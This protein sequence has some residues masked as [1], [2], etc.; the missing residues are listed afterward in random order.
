MN[1]SFFSHPT[2]RE[3][4]CSPLVSL[5][6]SPQGEAENQ[7]FSSVFLFLN[8]RR[9]RGSGDRP[10]SL[11]AC[12]PDRSVRSTFSNSNGRSQRFLLLL[13]VSHAFE[14]CKR[15]SLS[16]PHKNSVRSQKLSLWI[17][18]TTTSTLQRNHRR[19]NQSLFGNCTSLSSLW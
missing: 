15:L 16:S 7:P 9:K 4:V 5:L 13:L 2:T 8:S 3:G 14:S 12:G 17:S 6:S 19:T 18:S 11:A 10:R 1:G